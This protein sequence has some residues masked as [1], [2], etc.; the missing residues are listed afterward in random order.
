MSAGGVPEEAAWH[1]DVC[2][3]KRKQKRQQKQ[4][5]RLASSQPAGSSF[6]C[7]VALSSPLVLAAS[8]SSSSSG[9]DV[10][11]PTNQNRK[12]AQ[13]G[14]AVSHVDAREW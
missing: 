14:N 4:Q 9:R 11:L 8:A 12:S 10:L 6:V 13:E 5:L 7:D 3:S 1:D 2:L